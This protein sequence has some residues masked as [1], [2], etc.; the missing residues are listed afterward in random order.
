VLENRPIAAGFWAHSIP[1]SYKP[2]EIDCPRLSGVSR[3]LL[4]AFGEGRGCY[5]I[6]MKAGCGLWRSRAHLSHRSYST[7][8]NSFSCLRESWAA[9]S[10]RLRNRL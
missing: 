3:S 8:A 2:G 9:P 7:N 6:P 4:R 1:R 5:D 10:G